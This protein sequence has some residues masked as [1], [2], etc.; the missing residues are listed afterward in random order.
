[1]KKTV[2]YLSLFL[3]TGISAIAQVGISTDNSSPNPSA[4]L[5]VKGNNTG[6]IIPNSTTAS[7]TCGSSIT[8]NHLVSGGVAPVDKTVTYRTVTNMPGTTKCWIT[9]NLG[10]SKQA[11]TVSDN[12]EASAGWYWQ[13]NRKRVIC[14]MA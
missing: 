11:A 7:F 5:D 8:I 2:I 9:R 1:M 6:F 13:F 4:E 12:S 10:A 14:M 3:F